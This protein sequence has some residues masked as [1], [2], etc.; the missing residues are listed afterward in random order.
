MPWSLPSSDSAPTPGGWIASVPRLTAALERWCVH[1]I[2]DGF[3]AIESLIDGEV[4]CFGDRPTLLNLVLWILTVG[5]VIY[6]PK[7]WQIG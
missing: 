7:L 2:A 5:L 6:V 4:F 1:W 3:R